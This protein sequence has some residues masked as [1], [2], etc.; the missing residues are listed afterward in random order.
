MSTFC[1]S[2]RASFRLGWGSGGWPGVWR[3]VCGWCVLT[4]V[5]CATPL[6][7]QVS[8]FNA[9]PTDAAG[10]SYSFVRP[11]DTSRELEHASYEALVRTELE[12]QGLRA[13]PSGQASRFLVDMALTATLENRSTIRP[14]YQDAYVFRPGFRDA[15]G[16]IH[17]GYWG[18]D[19]FGPRWVGDQLIAVTVQVSSLRLRLLDARG[20]PPGQP[21][22][23]FEATA[24]HESEGLPLPVVAPYLVRAVFE[25][26]PGQN[27][28]LRVVRFDRKTGDVIRP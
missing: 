22:T 24:S 6:S 11:V 3:V 19:P 20:A 18:P 14:L 27:G 21:R 2:F 25:D 15:L 12:R 28:R 1:A 7:T 5:G 10:S 9:W 17:P 8:S 4:L 26:F 13:A 16:R 23:V